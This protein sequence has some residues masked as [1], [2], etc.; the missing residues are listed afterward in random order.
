MNG[1]RTGHDLLA[2]LDGKLDDSELLR[3]LAVLRQLRI[4]ELG[5]SP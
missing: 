5:A 3:A 1:Q 2:W 4:I